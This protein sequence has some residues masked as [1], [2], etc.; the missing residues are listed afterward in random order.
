M[1]RYFFDAINGH[2]LAKNIV[3]IIDELFSIERESL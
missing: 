2:D 1:R 3:D